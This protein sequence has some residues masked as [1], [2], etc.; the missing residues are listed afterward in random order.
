MNFDVF[1]LNY[2]QF[3]KTNSINVDTSFRCR[4]Q[5]PACA[6]QLNP[7]IKERLDA[8]S[9]IK[10]EHFNMLLTTFT[11]LHLCGQISDPIYHPTFLDLLQ[12]KYDNFKSTH[13]NIHTNGSGKKIDWWKKAF[14]ITD[15]NTKWVFALDGFTQEISNL[16]RIGTDAENVKEVMVL[17][18]NQNINIEWQYLVFEHNEHE[19]ED[20]MQ[21]ALSNNIT[22][23]LSRPDRFGI[24]N[25]HWLKPS[26]KKE[27]V[28]KSGNVTI[29]AI[30]YKP[31]TAIR[32][33]IVFKK[34]S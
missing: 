14:H 24:E 28:N 2:V 17:A 22:F 13:L 9:D 7:R 31:I 25:K 3:A 5:C 26:T 10:Q 8:S 4:L 15:E 19:V 16:Y 20:A 29:D 27:W 33:K 1:Y 21:F 23:L 30:A 12:N 32:D 6:R 34:K 18:A 11:K